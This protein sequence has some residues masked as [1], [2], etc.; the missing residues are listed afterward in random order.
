[1]MIV[2]EFSPDKLRP[3]YAGLSNTAMGLLGMV[4]PLI[5]AWLA[6]RSYDW[7]FALAARSSGAGLTSLRFWVHS[8]HRTNARFDPTAAE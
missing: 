3:T 1:M 7:L 6:S 4:S 5:G 8:P 2:L